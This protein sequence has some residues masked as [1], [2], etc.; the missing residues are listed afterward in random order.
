ML[1]MYILCHYIPLECSTLLAQLEIEEKQRLDAVWIA[2]EE[3]ECVEEW[4]RGWD[5]VQEHL[6]EGI[7]EHR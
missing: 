5:R 2:Y 3:H 6:V 1:P 7:K 4:K